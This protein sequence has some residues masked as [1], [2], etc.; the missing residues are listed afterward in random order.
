[1][2]VGL[3]AHFTIES[4]CPSIL[5]SLAALTKASASPSRDS[6]S[7]AVALCSSCSASKHHAGS[8]SH[9]R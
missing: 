2:L 4:I 3:L 5:L 1:M 9:K 8:A 7:A 6:A